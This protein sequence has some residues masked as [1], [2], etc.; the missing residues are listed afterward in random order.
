[1]RFLQFQDII[2]TDLLV[3]FIEDIGQL[4][5]STIQH[6]IYTIRKIIDVMIVAGIRSIVGIDFIPNRI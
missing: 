1:M 6:F 3:K 2:Y 4:N 5:A